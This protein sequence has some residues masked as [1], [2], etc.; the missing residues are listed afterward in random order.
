MMNLL[1]TIFSCGFMNI[2]VTYLRYGVKEH[3]QQRGSCAFGQQW[4]LN[5]KS[6][7]SRPSNLIHPTVTLIAVRHYPSGPAL[8]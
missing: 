1:R 6:H 7:L 3:V 2:S 5:S 8:K 4:R